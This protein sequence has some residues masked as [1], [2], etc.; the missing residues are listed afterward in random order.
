MWGWKEARVKPGR[1]CVSVIAAVCFV[2]QLAST[3]VV[4]LTGPLTGPLQTYTGLLLPRIIITLHVPKPF[5]FTVIKK[6]G[7]PSVHVDVRGALGYSDALLRKRVRA[8]GRYVRDTS[9]TTGEV[10]YLRVERV[11]AVN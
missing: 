1:V 6:P 7:R 3:K 9:V 11:E 4:P 8:Y 10:T 2:G 5:E